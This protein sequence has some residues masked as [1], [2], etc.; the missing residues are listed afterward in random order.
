MP[1]VMVAPEREVPGKPGDGG[2]ALAQANGQGVPEAHVA[3]RA[4]A[5]GH[6]VRNEEHTARQ[7]QRR[8]YEWG[9]VVELLDLVVDGQHE[10]KRQRADDDH[11][12]QPRGAE[13][14]LHRRSIRPPPAAQDDEH[15]AH[16]GHDVAPVADADGDERSQMQQHVKKEMVLPGGEVEQILQNGKVP[17]ARYRQKLRHALHDAQNNGRRDGHKAVLQLVFRRAGPARTD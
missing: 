10:E 5:R 11:E 13:V 12:E 6:F 4:R 8:T 14:A 7:Q 3:L 16:H 15:L 9:Y 17:G 1:A 2:H